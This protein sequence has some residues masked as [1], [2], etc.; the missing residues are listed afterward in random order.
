VTLDI[1]RPIPTREAYSLWARTYD[2]ENVVSTLDELAIS[3]LTPPLAGLALLDAGCGTARRLVFTRDAA[4]RRVAGVDLVFE[5][6][7][8]SRHD[9][10]RTRSLAVGDI[11]AL[12]AAEATFDV[13]WCRLAAGHIEQLES[14]YSELSRVARPCGFVIVTDFHP[15]AARRGHVRSFRDATGR[16]RVVEH[17]TH[18]ADDHE[19]AARR[20]GLS[21][22]ARLDLPVGPGVKHFYE[23]AG[24]LSRYERDCGLPLLLALRYRR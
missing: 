16:S 8:S 4:P 11:R 3:L 17:A 10:Q 19:R 18:E 14:F 5:M 15:E 2:E 6:I 23:A 1:A 7:L 20:S 21:L 12:P 9:P 24:V 22:D 13:V